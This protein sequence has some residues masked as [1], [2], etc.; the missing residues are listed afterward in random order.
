MICDKEW[1]NYIKQR[2]IEGFH[3]L[4]GEVNVVFELY[5][6]YIPENSRIKPTVFKNEMD[7]II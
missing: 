5:D 4:L 3:K 6:Q 1:E 7:N 2:I